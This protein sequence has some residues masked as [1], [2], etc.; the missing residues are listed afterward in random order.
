MA[1]TVN[2][3]TVAFATSLIGFGYALI[4]PSFYETKEAKVIVRRNGVMVSLGCLI[5]LAGF[6]K[7]DD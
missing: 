3:K 1:S 2:L 4:A 5:F 6:Q 7:I